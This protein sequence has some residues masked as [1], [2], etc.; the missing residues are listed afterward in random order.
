MFYLWKTF[1]PTIS[2]ACGPQYTPLRMKIMHDFG[3]VLVKLESLTI[4]FV[5]ILSLLSMGEVYDAF[6]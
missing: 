6:K 5:L 3:Q 4:C 1:L 2:L